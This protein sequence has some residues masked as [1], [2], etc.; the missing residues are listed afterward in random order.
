MCFVE[1][2]CHI[3]SGFLANFIAWLLPI[4]GFKDEETIRNR[5]KLAVSD[6]KISVRNVSFVP[7]WPKELAA[8]MES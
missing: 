2:D 5:V 8:C 3:W 4:S 6:C 1:S 7:H